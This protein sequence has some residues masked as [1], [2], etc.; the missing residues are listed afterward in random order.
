MK[1]GESPC[2]FRDDSRRVVWLTRQAQARADRVF[3]RG[4]WV[5]IGKQRQRCG[6]PVLAVPARRLA[7]HVGNAGA[8]EAVACHEMVIEK[9]QR[10]V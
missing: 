7:S 2:F 1:R 4:G 6:P 10:F 8:D 9:G 5:G 3:Q